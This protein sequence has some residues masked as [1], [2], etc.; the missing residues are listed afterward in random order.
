MKTLEAI[1]QEILITASIK[2]NLGMK[3]N[4]EETSGELEKLKKEVRYDKNSGQ[5]YWI[6]FIEI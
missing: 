6:K 4:S 3:Y 1:M 5:F 2:Y